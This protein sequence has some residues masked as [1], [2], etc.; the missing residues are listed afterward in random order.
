MKSMTA[1]Q[2]RGHVC[3]CIHHK[4]MEIA[5]YLKVISLIVLNLHKLL[6]EEILL[7]RFPGIFQCSLFANK[8]ELKLALLPGFTV[9]PFNKKIKN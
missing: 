9:V 8:L 5:N 4:F 2:L 7:N 1:A 6:P 3:A